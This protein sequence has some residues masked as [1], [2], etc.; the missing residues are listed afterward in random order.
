MSGEIDWAKVTEYEKRLQDIEK[1]KLGKVRIF[2]PKELIRKTNKIRTIQDPDLGLISYGTVVAEELS[3]INRFATNEEKGVFMLYLALHK[4]YPDVKLE[5]VKA[6]SI[7]DFA[8]LMKAIF[9]GQVFFPTQKPSE[10]GS[11]TA[12]TPRE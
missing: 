1:E 3:E 5:D 4:A 6:F 12:G 7:E 9:G 11:R 8:R 2:D 10:N